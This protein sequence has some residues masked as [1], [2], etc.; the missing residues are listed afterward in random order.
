MARAVPTASL[1]HVQRA[2]SSNAALRPVS[3]TPRTRLLF[4]G[5]PLRLLPH[6]SEFVLDVEDEDNCVIPCSLASI[7]AKP[8]YSKFTQHRAYRSSQVDTF[9]FKAKRAKGTMLCFSK[10]NVRSVAVPPRS[11]HDPAELLTAPPAPSKAFLPASPDLERCIAPPVRPCEIP[12]SS[13][14]AHTRY[15]PQQLHRLFGC[16]NVAGCKQLQSLSIKV[17][18]TGDPPL[19]IRS[20]VNIERGRKGCSLSQPLK[21]LNVVDMDICYGDG[22]SPAGYSYCLM[23][24]NRATR[25]TWVHGLK[26]MNGK[27]ISDALWRFFIDAGGFPRW[28]QCD[29]DPK[30]IGVK[31]RKLL[32]SHAIRLTAAPPNC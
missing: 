10:E 1:G 4:P 32:N 18:D 23:L 24:V 17:V 8:D 29:F 6:L 25:K 22:V 5:R 16:C 15:T 20:V 31:V 12:K 27:T 13:T 14:A 2:T 19:S 21:A 9:R 26:D 3:P 11:H 30:F 7:H 28:I